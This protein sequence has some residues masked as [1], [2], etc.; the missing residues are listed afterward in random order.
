MITVSADTFS[1]K[2]RFTSALSDSNED[3]LVDWPV[4]LS[5][6]SVITRFA[7]VKDRLTPNVLPVEVPVGNGPDFRGFINLFTGKCQMFKAGSKTGEFEE[8]D[9]PPELRELFDSYTEQFTEAVAA[10]D[11]K[12]IEKYLAGDKLSREDVVPAMKKAMAAGDIVPLFCGSGEH[13][14]GIRT[15]LTEIVELLPSPAEAPKP[16]DAPLLGRVF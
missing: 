4:V 10:T 9:V 13:Q 15:L 7:E 8:T 5:V 11:D 3:D 1:T 12:L 16:A 2:S 6:I 14:F